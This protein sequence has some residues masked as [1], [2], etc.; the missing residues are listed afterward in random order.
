MALTFT[1]VADYVK[2]NSGSLIKKAVATGNTLKYTT[3]QPG[4][5]FAEALHLI[6]ENLVL[7]SG[8]CGFDPQSTTSLTDRILTVTPIKVNNSYCPTDLE[9]RFLSLEMNAGS[10]NTEMPLEEVFMDSKVKSIQSENEKVMWRGDTTL[11][12]NLAR[13]DGFL[14]VLDA[15]TVSG[16]SLLPITGTYTIATA[17]TTIVDKVWEMV[18]K[19]PAGLAN[20]TDKFLYMSPELFNTYT[21]ALVK[22]NA[23]HYNGTPTDGEILIPGTT[24]KAVSIDGLSGANAMVLSTKGNMY[25]GMDLLSDL[26]NMSFFYSQDNNDVRFMANYKLGVQIAYPSYVVYYKGV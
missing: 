8:N 22:N 5:K 3:I 11:S 7:Q 2:Q 25:V 10:Y 24:V 26:D 18:S 23:F 19:V 4:I 17:A 16:G 21:L 12:G 13:F 14:K 9:K 15:A 6:D 20:A 1:N